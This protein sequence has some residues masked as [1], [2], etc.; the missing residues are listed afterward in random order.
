MSATSETEG[1]GVAPVRLDMWADIACP[2]CFIGQTR[3]D[4]AIAAERAEGRDVQVLPK[5]RG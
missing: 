5:M 1:V 4:A 2:W 3:L